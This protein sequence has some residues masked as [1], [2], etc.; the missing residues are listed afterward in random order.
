MQQSMQATNIKCM[1]IPLEVRHL[2]IFLDQSLEATMS[3]IVQA[4]Q[5]QRRAFLWSL[6]C[7]Q[8]TFQN[9]LKQQGQSC[10][11]VIAG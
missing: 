7:S 4:H 11:P 1:K 10:A 8:E 2:C 9:Q 5:T 3:V 6:P